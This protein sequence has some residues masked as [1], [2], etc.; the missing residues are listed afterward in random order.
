VSQRDY[1]LLADWATRSAD[2]GSPVPLPPAL[3]R[4][5]F[6][7]FRTAAPDAPEQASL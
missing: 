3:T 2:A 6:D 4:Y 1:E 5:R 7:P